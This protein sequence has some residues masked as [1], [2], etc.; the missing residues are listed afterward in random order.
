MWTDFFS[1]RFFGVLFVLVVVYIY[2]PTIAIKMFGKSVR[3]G[4]FWEIFYQ[5]DHKSQPQFSIDTLSIFMIFGHCIISIK[6]EKLLIKMRKLSASPPPTVIIIK[7]VQWTDVFYQAFCHLTSLIYCVYCSH[8]F[9]MYPFQIGTKNLIMVWY[10]TTRPLII[11]HK[12]PRGQ[13]NIVHHRGG[14][15]DTSVIV[16]RCM[17][18][19]NLCLFWIYI[20]S[21]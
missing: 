18:F 13:T 16:F 8:M 19:R 3:F 20:F 11:T 21:Q 9:T 1:F 12:K 17:C 7:T 6:Y 5:S 4:A 15:T 2:A 10:K 14:K